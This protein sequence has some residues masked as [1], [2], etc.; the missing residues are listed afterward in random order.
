MDDNTA[1]VDPGYKTPAAQ[2]APPAE[3]NSVVI[4]LSGK[5]LTNVPMDIFDRTDA[6]ELNLSNNALTGAIPAEVRNLSNLEKLDL[7]DNKLGGVPA[8]VG[9]LSKLV[10]LDLSNNL[11]TGLPLEIGNLKNLATLNLSGNEFSETDLN[12]ILKTLPDL[13]VVR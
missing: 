11:L 4:D 7:S 2:P 1:N 13:N 10:E 5:G 8:E 6:V 3:Q 9:Q 12:Q